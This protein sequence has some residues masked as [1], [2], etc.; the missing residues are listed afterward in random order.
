[1]GS[2]LAMDWWTVWWVWISIALLLAILEVLAPGY[3]FLGFSLGAL[4]FGIGVALG[5]NVGFA[6]A[7]VIVAVL[8]LAAYIALRWAFRL[9]GNSPKIWTRDIN[10]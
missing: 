7:L 5:V 10:E 4:L 2:I 9:K 1:M 3:I 6:A 8:S